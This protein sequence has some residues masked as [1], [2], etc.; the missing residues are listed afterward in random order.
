MAGPTGLVGGGGPRGRDASA[1]IS[2]NDP[3][4]SPALTEELQIVP[5]DP[6]VARRS[7]LY[8]SEAKDRFVVSPGWNGVRSERLLPRLTAAAPEDWLARHGPIGRRTIEG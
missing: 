5:V 7:R 4:D 3:A 1:S 6:G 8:E 2:W